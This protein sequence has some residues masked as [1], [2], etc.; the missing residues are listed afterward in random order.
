MSVNAVLLGVVVQPKWSVLSNSGRTD[1]DT[2]ILKWYVEPLDDIIS[3]LF[4]SLS[5]RPSLIH[6][7]KVVTSLLT[8]FF[9]LND[10]AVDDVSHGNDFFRIRRKGRLHSSSLHGTAKTNVWN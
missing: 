4:P 8:L 2:E 1:L 3:L 9:F 5:V 7:T 6:F 10:I